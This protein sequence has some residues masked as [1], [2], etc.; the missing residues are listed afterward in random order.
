[1]NKYDELSSKVTDVIAILNSSLTE[2]KGHDIEVSFLESRKISIKKDIEDLQKELDDIKDTNGEVKKQ[3]K[4]KLDDIEYSKNLY[5]TKEQSLVALQNKLDKDR[6][7]LSDEQQGFVADKFQL[8]IKQA[9]AEAKS[10]MAS[11]ALTEANEKLAQIKNIENNSNIVQ[12]EKD[13]I[14]KEANLKAL[15]DTLNERLNEVNEL[16][17]RTTK[18]SSDLDK[19]EDLLK[20]SNEAYDKKVK[21]LSDLQSILNSQKSDND[22]KAKDLQYLEL[23]INKIIKDRNIEALINV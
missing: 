11:R 18:D 3:L 8:H 2:L 16:I 10:I 12:R 14:S 5:I 20:S 4:K 6:A 17:E 7:D 1:M 21:E 13:V 15:Q 19:R 23:R 22:K 9:E